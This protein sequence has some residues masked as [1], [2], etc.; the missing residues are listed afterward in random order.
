MSKPDEL[1]DPTTRAA[2]LEYVESHLVAPAQER[3]DRAEV[4]RIVA[5]GLAA[6]GVILSPGNW[7]RLVRDLTD[8]TIAPSIIST[9]VE[10]ASRSEHL[11]HA[12]AEGLAEA[13]EA[14][15][16]RTEKE[17]RL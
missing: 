13:A 11:F 5:R 2:A 6:Q 16:D 8:E 7:A 9:V 3:L 12:F 4:R 15:A 1:L 10:L 14:H 17:S